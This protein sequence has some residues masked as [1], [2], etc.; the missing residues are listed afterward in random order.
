MKIGILG[1]GQL[2]R[3]MALAG[4][5]MGF[6]FAFYD[7]ATECC[8]A[9]LGQLF[10]GDFRDSEKLKAFAH[11]VDIITYEFENVP[12]ETLELLPQGS[13]VYPSK[14]ALEFTQDRLIEKELFKRLNIPTPDFIAIHGESELQDAAK[15]L[16]YPFVLKTRSGG[17]DGK[18]QMVLRHQSELHTAL[19][20]CNATPCIGEAWVDYEREVSLITVCSTTEVQNYDLN[21]NVHRGGVLHWT[22]NRPNDD[23]LEQAILHS[24][25]LAHELNYRGVLTIEFF[26]CGK[27][28]LA[29]EYAPRVHN[30]GHWTIEGA[31]CSQFENHLRAILDLPLGS[32]KSLGHSMMINC[33]G[34]MPEFNTLLGIQ[35][36][37][38]HNYSK[39]A[40]KGR[41]VGHLTLQHQTEKELTHFSN[42]LN[43]TFKSNNEVQS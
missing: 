27:I 43:Q 14:K 17:Y 25:A 30:S 20:L 39:T 18:G 19:D 34:A 5:P 16:G 15:K 28:L 42:Q 40:R 9:P 1:A 37:H 21:E 10:R 8:A 7:S 13:V 33:L 12:L 11:S 22:K 6:E 36:L 23:M 2:A 29:N 4:I 24:R 3:M 41:K 35:G 31:P 32:T 26:Q 38:Y